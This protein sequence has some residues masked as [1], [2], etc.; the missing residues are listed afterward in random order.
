MA[1]GGPVSGSSTQAGSGGCLAWQPPEPG[2]ADEPGAGPSRKRATAPFP[3]PVVFPS[4]EELLQGLLSRDERAMA[5]FY[6]QYQVPIL[7]LLLRI[8][9]N[10]QSAEDA[11]QEGMVKVWR[12]IGSYDPAL[13]SLF[14]WAAR[15]CSNTA[16]DQLRKGNSRMLARTASLD[17]VIELRHMAAEGFQPEHIGVVELLQPLR[18]EYRQVMDLI[19]LQGYTQAEAADQLC[20]PVGTV[21]TWTGRAR[22]LLGYR[23]GRA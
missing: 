21:K 15:V 17:K 9:R 5:D 2:V 8:T 16:I 23:P 22:Y 13:S 10:R 11:L 7:A 14:T 19:Y 1:A 20:V 6:H 18:P 12:S 4:P 3:L